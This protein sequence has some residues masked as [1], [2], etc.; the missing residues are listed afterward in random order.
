MSSIDNRDSNGF[1]KLFEEY[2][3][4][5]TR[6]ANSY[7]RDIVVAESLFVDSLVEY[8]QRR[9]TLPPDVNIPGYILTTLKNKALNYLRH[10]RVQDTASD[11]IKRQA[12]VE[13]EFR[14]NSLENFTTEQ[15]FTEEI[16][17]IVR[18]TLESM[19]YK[20]RRI[21]EMSRFEHRRNTE[22]AQML[23]ISV[24]TVEFH[25]S[26]ILKVLRVNLKDYMLCFLVLFM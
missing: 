16:R 15:L 17:E 14:I 26:K 20:S 4:P 12:H 23:N 10:Q 9:T 2:K 7:V 19:P 1:S 21:F 13:L 5:F 8:W 3:E 22:I 11:Y 24:K 6:F 25:I 18:Q